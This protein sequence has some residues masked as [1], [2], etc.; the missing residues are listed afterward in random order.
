[1][2]TRKIVSFCVAVAY[3]AFAATS[4]VLADNE[5]DG[6][7]HGG[8]DGAWGWNPPNHDRFGS[9]DGPG[10]GGFFDGADDYGSGGGPFGGGGGALAG[11]MGLFAFLVSLITGNSGLVGPQRDRAG[12]A[13]MNLMMADSQSQG[14]GSNS[15]GDPGGSDDGRKPPGR[16]EAPNEDIFD[17]P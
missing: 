11:R 10:R 8:S 1:M 7:A 12:F 4:P 2:K 3:G 13:M 5:F 16:I 15:N 17:A 9:G 6:G 14:D